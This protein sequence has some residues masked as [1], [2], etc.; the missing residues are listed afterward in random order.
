MCKKLLTVRLDL[1]DVSLNS[2]QIREQQYST[3][4]EIVDF[5]YVSK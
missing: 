2:V 5:E 4:F 1:A 3:L